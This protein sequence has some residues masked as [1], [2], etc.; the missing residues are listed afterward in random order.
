MNYKNYR[1]QLEKQLAA[2]AVYL[3]D[4][5]SPAVNYKIRQEIHILQSR[6]SDID[7]MPATEISKQVQFVMMTV[8]SSIKFK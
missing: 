4:N 3:L 6:I 7:R 1:A 8:E 2:Y 5:D